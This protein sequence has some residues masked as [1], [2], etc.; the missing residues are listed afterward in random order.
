MEVTPAISLRLRRAVQLNDLA[1]VKRYLKNSIKLLY[2]PELTNKSNTSL[3]YAAQNGHVEI[4]KYLI[5]LGHDSNVQVKDYIF[6]SA[7]TDQG[8][9]VNADGQCAL[10]IAASL[11]HVE[12]IDLLCES[13]PH[14]VNRKDKHGRTPLL[15][16]IATANSSPASKSCKA[17]LMLS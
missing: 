3:H 7:G 13:F 15:L 16:C 6:T 2:N 17:L 14:T 8:I 1:L 10:H 9:S 5:S 12:M 11:H 4:A